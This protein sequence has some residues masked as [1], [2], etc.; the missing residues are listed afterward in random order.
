[1]NIQQHVMRPQDVVLLLKIIALKDNPW[2]Q[3][4]LA[5]QLFMSQSEISQS[6]SRSKYAGL[7]HFNGKKVFKQGFV[8]FLQ[9][10]IK[11]VFPQQPGVMTRGVLTAHSASPLNKIIQS[12]E[13]YVWPSGKGS[14]RGQSVTPLYKSVV[15][16]IKLDS[17]LYELLAL[18]DAIR[19][20]RT[21]EREIALEELKKSIV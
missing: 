11:Y 9:Y 1:M 12:N 3:T 13:V 2:S 20:G 14:A 8:E 21:R 16:A 4:I 18:V 6:I 5:D 7:L 10:G 17:L 19:I 15:Y